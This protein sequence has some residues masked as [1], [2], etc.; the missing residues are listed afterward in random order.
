MS[1]YT[2]KTITSDLA[3]G[4][5]KTRDKALDDL[6]Q[7]L[8]R[9]NA[10]VDLSELGDK[11]YHDIFEALFKTVLEQKPK[12]FDKKTSKPAELR[13]TKCARAVRAAAARGAPKLKQKT[14]SAII[15]HITQV[16]PGPGD[17]FVRP[18]LSDYVKALTELLSRSANVE[19]FSRKNGQL[20]QIC[21]DFLLDVISNRIPQ[22]GPLDQGL[23][24]RNSPGPSTPRSTL[25]SNSGSLLSHKASELTDG[26]PARDALEGL[27]C[28]ATASNAHILSRYQ[29]IAN[30]ALRVLHLHSL[31]LGSLQ[32]MSFAIINSIMSA[33]QLDDPSYTGELVQDLLPLMA[34][35]WR[36]DKV[37]QDDT[38]KSLRNEILRTILISQLHIEHL[39]VNNWNENVR[40]GVIHL[41]EPLWKEYSKRSSSNQLR[42]SHISFTTNLLP[43]D[44]L[45][46]GI[47]GLDPLDIEAESQW[48]I[49]QCIAA[50]EAILVRQKPKTFSIQRV[51]QPRKRR[52]VEQ[53]ENRIRIR[54]KNRKPEIIQPTLQVIPFMLETRALEIDAVQDVLQELVGLTTHKDTSLASWALVACSSCLQLSNATD[55]MI[56]D[57]KQ[58]WKVA[59]RAVSLQSTCRAACLLI[60]SLLKTDVLP[61][62]SLSDDINSIT[63]TAD[64]NGPAILC[65]TSVALMGHLL[66]VRNTILP[67]ASQATSNYIIRWALMR[68][69]PADS[70]SASQRHSIQPINLVNLLRA[71]C[72][73][74][75]IAGNAQESVIGGPFCETWKLQ[76]DT[77][78]FNEY[79]LLL[80]HDSQG[81]SRVVR[82]HH[83][84]TETTE[85]ASDSNTCFPSRKLLLEL[86]Y[87]KLEELSELCTSWSKKPSEGGSQISQEK[88]ESLL[89]ACIVGA[90]LLPEISHM[91]SSQSALVETLIMSNAERGITEAF[92]SVEANSFVQQL[93]RSIRSCIPDLTHVG[94]ERLHGENEALLGLLTLAF[95]ALS[96]HNLAKDSTG[97][98]DMMEL[99]DEFESQSSRA[100][101]LTTSTSLPRSV[102]QICLSAP[103]FYTDTR[104]RLNLIVAS[105]RD[106]S[107]VGI[108]PDVFI[109]E[110]VRM[111]DDELLSCYTLLVE[112]FRSDMVASPDRALSVIQR[113][114]EVVGSN[115]YRC[116]EVALTTCIEVIHGL[117]SMWLN[118]SGELANSVGDLYHY[119]IDTCLDANFFSPRSLKA[120]SELLFT[121]LKLQPS[122]GTSLKLDSCRTSLLSILREGSMNVKYFVAERIAGLFEL[123]ILMLHDE[124]FVDV[125]GSLPADP[126]SQAGIACRLLVLSNLAQRWPTLLRRCTYHIFETPGK[127]SSVSE[128]ARRCIADI[129]RS[130]ALASPKEL[131]RLFTRQLLYTWM[132]S[133]SVKDIPFAIFGF[134]SLG[135]LLTTAQSDA[136]GLSTM[137]GQDSIRTEIARQIGKTEVELLQA[138]FAASISYSTVFTAAFE[139]LSEDNGETKIKKKMGNKLF[140]ESIYINFVD[141]VA[142]FFDIIDQE[143]AVEKVFGRSEELAYAAK[144]YKGITGI[145]RSDTKL[146]PNQQPMFRSKYVIHELARLCQGTEFLFNE[147]WTPAL[148]VSIAR[149][150]FNTVHPALGSL[151]A[152]S[153][154]RKVRIL[155]CLA[156]PV[157]LESYC[158]EMLLNSVRMFITDSE[159]ADDALGISQY[160]L[161]K[162]APYLQETPSFLAGYSLS[163]LASLRVF[164]ESSQ[165]STTQESQFKATMSKA[166]KFHEWLASYL[167][168]YTS[169]AFKNESQKASF[170]SITS[171]AARIRSS[172]NAE[173]STFE[174]KLLLDILQDGSAKH[175]LLNEPSRDLAMGLLC[176]DFTIPEHVS[177]DIISSDSDA[178]QHASAVWKSCNTKDLSENY[179]SWA[180]RVVG[181]AFAASGD[182]PEGIIAESEVATYR[183]IAPGPNGSE[184]G[185]LSLLQSLTSNSDALTA[186]LAESVLRAAISKAMLQEDEPL[187]IACQRSLAEPLYL[188]SQWSLYRSPP[189]ENQQAQPS[190]DEQSIWDSNITSETWLSDLSILMANSVPDSVLLSVLSPVL[191][192][193]KGFAEKAFPFIVHLVLMFQLE[194][195]QILKRCLSAALKTWL[196][197]NVVSARPKI[198]L[199]I[200]T[201]LYLRTQEYPKEGS[202]GDRLHWLEI[203]YSAAA[204][205]ATHCGMYK[206]ALLFAELASIETG[207]QSRRASAAREVD[208]SSTLLSI[209]ENIDDPDAYYGLSEEASFS[210]VLSRITYE[211]DGMKSVAFLGAQFDSDSRLQN[212]YSTVDVQALV[213]AL[214]A[215]GLSGLSHSL[216]QTHQTVD[217][218]PAAIENTF[219]S[220]QRLEMWNL[221]APKDSESFAVTTYKAYQ[222]IHNATETVSI[223]NVVYEGF[224]KTIGSA[225]GTNRPTIAML[226]N[227]LGVLAALSELDD[228]M[229]VSRSDDLNEAL[230]VLQLRGDWMKRGRYDDVSN[231][232]SC[233]GTT[234]SMLSQHSNILHE[235]SLSTA[236][237][238]KAEVESLLMSSGLYRFHEAKQ[239]SLKI[240]TSL[241]KLIPTCRNLD[242]HIDASVNVEVANSLWDQGEMSTAIQMLQAID[243]D[244]VLNKQ[245]IPVTK[246]DL[247]AKIG[248]R[249]S[250]AR[251]EKPRDIQ[252]KYLEPA[253]KEIGSENYGTEAGLVFHQFALFCDGQLQDAD[254]LEDLERLQNLRKAKSDEVSDLKELIASTK[255]SQ[256]RKRYDYVLAKE[257]QWLE[258]DEQELRRVEQTRSEFV[259]LSVENYLLSL[260]ASDAHNNDALRFTALWLE[261]SG[262]EGTNN[263]VARYLSKVP[264]RKFA[265][266][267][268]QLTS[269][270][271]YT[272]S[273]FQKL[274]LELVYNICVDHPYHGMYQIWSGTKVRVQSKDEVAV[275]R[276]KATEKVAQRLAATKPVANIWL[277]IEK[278]SKYYHGLAVD[279]DTNKYKAGAKFPLKDSQAGLNLVIGLAKYHI[280]PPTMHVEIR[281]CKDYSTVP[282]IAKLEPTMTIAGGV[283]APKIITAIGT[284]GKKYKQL[285]KG[286]HDDL[287]QDAI[288]EQVFAAVSSLLKH[289]RSAQQ[290]NLG[291]RTYKVLPLTASSGLI[292]FVPNTIPLHEFLM[293]AHERYYPKDLKGSQCRKEIFNVQN[294]NIDT[295]ISTYRKVTDRFHPV[296]KYF[297]MEYFED[298]DE[299]YA[300][301]LAYTRTTAAISMLGHVLGLGDRHGHNI[302]LDTKTGEV[303]HIDLGVAFEAGRILPVPELVPFRLTRDIVDGMGIS[304]TEGV[305]RRCCE[306]TLDALREEQYSIMTIL[307]VLRYDPLY[308][309]SISPL[310]LAK[311]QKAREKDENAP[312]TDD[313]DDT[314]DKKNKENGRNKRNGGAEQKNVNE[315]SE[316]DRA[317]EVVRKK[318]SKALSV[319]ATVNDLINQATD[320]RHLAVLYSGWAAY[321]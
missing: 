68:W 181:R 59:T 150:L 71:C 11:A 135:E 149:K 274:L 201:L 105:Q 263:A 180:G 50:L 23:I 188:T 32:T 246:A 314:D 206:T 116:C 303:V 191:E 122:Y 271:Q 197:P 319:T 53:A 55:N 36:A 121:L 192:K 117:S 198:V 183:K 132:E 236:V 139:P 26:E 7:L 133:D 224:A 4:S 266:L 276:V 119:F 187:L 267:M 177:N 278:T 157:A 309:W 168:K 288:M 295:R 44:Y 207:R 66:S 232:L 172:G 242:L 216:Q 145:A 300:K 176:G 112:L 19:F 30:A 45:Q 313:V 179:L 217:T 104:C 293:P 63:T 31:S 284:N 138:N 211:N 235:A 42:L 60:H 257:K 82:G 256:L 285:V 209:F 164:L 261:R 252:K 28:L 52:R 260:I 146:P 74:K 237:M 34:H 225:T 64:V 208:L 275:Q 88:F 212:G 195:Q 62:H 301:R 130:L 196:Q 200:N 101:T 161:E 231:I 155:I 286:G 268:N 298:P 311:L 229:H 93:L 189:S 264:T 75:L 83:L 78:Q 165:S 287:R 280:P 250:V 299:W 220:A 272:D 254:G 118:D 279:R 245:A 70:V 202:I 100:I 317:L 320:E 282:T 248:D 39:A 37:S 3:T 99:D 228:L 182:I 109:D 143:D 102:H 38:I 108:V 43:E 222:A 73:M 166:T 113:L 265:N 94:M 147:L 106:D 219:K 316:A 170:K 251:R 124:V 125:L 67:S 205:A 186:G 305:F 98:Y 6:N 58:L 13:L 321:A 76:K 69:S 156:G 158:L 273:K 21:V 123:Y 218:S 215:I 33:T 277:S 213:S 178:V 126:E 163:T 294:R 96:K 107:Q 304:K 80:G 152:C 292:E 47:F 253:L 193:V 190:R 89:S 51:E 92:A 15:D 169:L 103:C 24:G 90:M 142:F 167:D 16:L 54:L 120:L 258:L 8:S 131:F 40:E 194:Q 289:H 204:T 29:D 9:N 46:I 111:S 97:S 297:F 79:L 12:Y 77:R 185:L 226:R 259:R 244:S 87:P 61:Y 17:G 223:R 302:L 65:D 141:I 137:R 10:A 154:L 140:T 310:R 184:M 134:E 84:S 159:C 210:N 57:W 56:D 162:G 214:S 72:G 247:L 227:K 48:G 91:N 281:A 221:P 283:S 27:L 20:W 14:L 95:D 127:I 307:D 173:Q 41:L 128:H 239:E 81:L 2:V 291:I 25:R 312:L 290:R 269:R 35:W 174:S 230:G 153:V 255:E 296:M 199:L 115:E 315:P 144:I 151:H 240:A 243:R 241:S 308:T 110:L 306:F 160:L 5:V 129:S 49:L 318:L 85:A 136:I 270:L 86:F 233:R 148:V 171:A 22:N 203:D 262:E 175:E 249:M 114:G 1:A 234:M 238:R 18:L